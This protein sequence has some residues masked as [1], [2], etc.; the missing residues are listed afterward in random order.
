[1]KNTSFAQKNVIFRALNRNR[2]VLFGGTDPVVLKKMN[3]TLNSNP[4]FFSKQE[5]SFLQNLNPNQVVKRLNLNSVFIVE[6]N[7]LTY[8]NRILGRP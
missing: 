7:Y 6:F 2:T 1:M 3:T 8:I 4:F 5:L